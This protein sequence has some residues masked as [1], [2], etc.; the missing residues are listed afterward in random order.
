MDLPVIPTQYDSCI[1]GVYKHPQTII[2]E[3][4]K[5]YPLPRTSAGTSLRRVFDK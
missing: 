5:K 2:D 4:N 1:D 3:L